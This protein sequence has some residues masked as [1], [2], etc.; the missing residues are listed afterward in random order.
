MT[1]AEKGALFWE[2]VRA[3][4]IMQALVN[5][6]PFYIS[7]LLTSLLMINRD[8]GRPAVVLFCLGF[9]IGEGVSMVFWSSE[10]VKLV[11]NSLL[12]LMPDTYTLAETLRVFRA[13]FPVVLTLII[14]L[15]DFTVDRLP[16]NPTDPL[17]IMKKILA[18]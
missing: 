9:G 7:W 2:Q 3:K 6:V 16:E 17:F 11:I 5:I 10:E 1:K 14:T 18:A 8:Y 15:L 13:F 12:V 4:R